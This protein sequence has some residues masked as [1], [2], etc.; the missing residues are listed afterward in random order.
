MS[1]MKKA[2][3]NYKGGKRELSAAVVCPIKRA[4]S[5]EKL[6]TIKILFRYLHNID[7]SEGK[8]LSKKIVLTFE[9]N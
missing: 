8:S 7:N 3:R 2:T 4:R 6:E 9:K 5:E 1:G